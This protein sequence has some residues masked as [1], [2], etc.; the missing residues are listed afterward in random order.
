MLTVLSVQYMLDMTCI[1]LS[2][3][4]MGGVWEGVVFVRYRVH[5]G[6]PA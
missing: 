6:S 4:F 3:L 5:Q 1:I 2:S